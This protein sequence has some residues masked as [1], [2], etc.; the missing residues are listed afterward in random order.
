MNIL[1]IE[2]SCDDTCIA[3]IK[4]SD[5]TNPKFEVLKNVI[6][7]QIEIH[8]KWGGVYPTL[9]KRE[10]QK[11][12]PLI[13]KKILKNLDIDKIDAIA[14]TIGPGLEPCL[15]VGL[16]FAKKLSEKWKKPLIPVNHI[17]GHIAANFIGGNSKF[18]ITNYKNLFPA[19]CLIVSGGHT[20]LILMTNYGK[21]KILGETRDDAAGE[22]FDKTARILG[23]GYP[24]GPAIAAKAAKFQI[25]NY[26]SQ[27]NPKS[28]IQNPTTAHL[29]WTRSPSPYS[30]TVAQSAIHLPRPMIHQKNYDFSFSGLKTAV[31]YDYKKRSSKE[32]KSKKYI[33]EMSFEIQQTIIDVLISKTLKAVKDYKAKTIILGGGVI[34][35]TELKKQFKEKMK[36]EIPNSKLYI[37]AS[38]L[39]TDN[40][41]MIGITGYFLWLNNKSK[42]WKNIKVNA[43]LRV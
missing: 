22:C 16:N 40:A 8:R 24:G 19:M 20:Q 13:L 43:N 26:K 21:Y 35:N 38:K 34:A 3:L 27:I 18:K 11:N 4:C 33:Q 14:V 15:W 31:L 6:S 41:V 17:E 9:A 5:K 32:K 25:Q 2:T 7:S 42:N 29:Q 30:R 37:P 23:L 28:K 36:K 10:H 39:C 12:L 1:A